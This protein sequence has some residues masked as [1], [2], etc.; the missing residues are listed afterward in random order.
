MNHYVGLDVSLKTVFICIV[1][2]KGRVVKE[3]ELASTPDFAGLF[4]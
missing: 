4:D 1:N 2:D 3:Q